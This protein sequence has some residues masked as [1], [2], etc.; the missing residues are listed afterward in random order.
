MKTL[1]GSYR[2]E[3]GK[4][5]IEWELRAKDEKGGKPCFSASGEYDGGSGQNIDT[6]AKAYPDDA[7]VQQIA[8]VWRKYHLNDMKAGTPEQ[9]AEIEQA[10]VTA[11]DYA[12]QQPKAE[13]YFYDD[14]LTQPNWHSL[15]RLFSLDSYY[16]W[17]C[18]IL[19]QANLY[20]V[21][22]ADQIK[23]GTITA[24]GGFPD[25]V[26]SGARGYRFGE[27][28]LYSPIPAEVL[29]QIESWASLP[30][31]RPLHLDKAA[32]WLR[33]HGLKLRI[34]ES[35][36]KTAPWEPAGHHYRVT[37][38]REATKGK[39]GRLVFDFWGSQADMEAGKDATPYDVLACISSDI[40]TPETFEDFCSEFGYDQ[41]SIKAKQT[42]NRAN[43][44]AQRLR[45]FLTEEEQ[46]TLAKIR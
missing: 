44:F 11:E 23:A 38:I 3:D 36:T 26:A 30:A 24:T 35:D 7:M 39:A 14:A 19:K 32:Q 43:K 34:T 6:I 10:R 4:A 22:L 40:Y 17:E 25:E 8:E 37:I 12:R 42:F 18:D 28:W 27:R 33:E 1:K 20:E 45:A 31:R 2:T 41:D 5:Q 15:C 13:Q 16:S 21:P 29:K 9:Q 46:E